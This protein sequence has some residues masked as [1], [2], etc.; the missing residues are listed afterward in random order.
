MA[1]GYVGQPGSTRWVCEGFGSCDTAYT[2]DGRCGGRSDRQC[3][4]SGVAFPGPQIGILERLNRGMLGGRHPGRQ[5]STQPSDNEPELLWPH[6]GEKLGVGR[7]V[8]PLG[9][10]PMAV[11]SVPRRFT[12]SGEELGVT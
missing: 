9:A 8:W 4:L 10:A 3:G 11:A 6:V 5:G 1:I 2:K 12:T 7:S